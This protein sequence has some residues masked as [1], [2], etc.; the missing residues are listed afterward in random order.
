[1]Q[2]KL[3]MHISKNVM[4]FIAFLDCA[5]TRTFFGLRFSELLADRVILGLRFSEL[6]AAKA[7]LSFAL[8]WDFGSRHI[9]DFGNVRVDKFFVHHFPEPL[10]EWSK[11]K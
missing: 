10:G 7:V 6:L 5:R 8:S 2:E 9:G 1:M 3:S 11:R 4:L